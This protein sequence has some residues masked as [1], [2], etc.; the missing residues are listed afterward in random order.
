M[1]LEVAD[2]TEENSSSVASLGPLEVHLECFRDSGGFEEKP[3]SG[4]MPGL[5]GKRG[6]RDILGWADR[7]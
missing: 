1:V 4:K 2:I 3:I 7:C 5:A 6:N